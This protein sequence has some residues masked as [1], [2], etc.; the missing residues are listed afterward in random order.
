M[1]LG[2]G[3]KKKTFDQ[4]PSNPSPAVSAVYKLQGLNT[5]TEDWARK[6]EVFYATQEEVNAL[7][8]E[9][10]AE[11][12]SYA[13]RFIEDRAGKLGS[14]PQYGYH[15]QVISG[16]IPRKLPLTDDDLVRLLRWA[17]PY[18]PV[19]YA[20]K[21]VERFAKDHPLS[22]DLQNQLRYHLRPSGRSNQAA[23]RL[24]KRIAELLGEELEE[25]FRIDLDQPWAKRLH[26]D[27][28]QLDDAYRSAMTSFLTHAATAE[29]GKP[30]KAWL[31]EAQARLEPLPEDLVTSALV[32]WGDAF[33]LP[34]SETPDE[35]WPRSEWRV[36]EANADLM[37]G[38]LWIATLVAN[39]DL[40]R[41]VTK[42]GVS[43][44]R[45][46]PEYGPR[47]GKVTNAAVWALG[48]IDRPLA[49][50]QLAILRSKIKNKSVQKQIDKAMHAAADRLG[51]PADE[52]EE[53]AVPEYGLT[54]V[55]VRREAFGDFTTELHVTGTG[56]TELRWIKPDGKP[57]KSVPK[58]VKDDHADD[59]KELKAAAKDIQKI[60]PAQ[61]DR[62]D[63]MHLKQKSW[64]Y[65]VWAEHYLNHPLVGALARRLIWTLTHEG[66]ATTATWLDDGLVDAEGHPVSV[67]RACAVA[68]WHPVGNAE[69]DILA[70]RAFFENRQIKQ[71]F[72]QAH[73]EVYL[74]T[75][76]ERNTNVYSNRFAAHVIKQHQFNALCGVR[77]WK[78][79]LR[80]LVD[81]EYPPATLE[82]PEWD[83]RAEFWV[84]G[85]GDDYGTDTNETGTFLRLA[86][87]QV[88]F[89]PLG[90]AQNYAHAGG[91]GYTWSRYRGEDAP[92]AV[93]L[94]Q[95][96]PLVFSEV[97]R[98]VDLFVG[99]A[100]VGND[101][102][103]EDGGPE[104]RFRDY[105]Q[106]YSFGDLSGTATTRKEILERLV[107]RLK[108][109]DRCSFTA[110]FLVVRGDVRTYKIHLG[111]GNILMEPNDQYL[112]IV[113]GRGDVKGPAGKV[114]LPFEGDRTL[115]IILSKAFL[116]ADDTKITD[117]TILSQIK[118]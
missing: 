75:D 37:K 82:L 98:D 116:L 12:V 85:I 38:L 59:L 87:D 117:R 94:D 15:G 65:D 56:T 114:F 88:R 74:L 108:I 84:E 54:G 61:R 43:G 11:F 78:N 19:G 102:T 67:D 45:K 53:M 16:L 34:A 93:P 113:P 97:M 20:V 23:Q 55:G 50:G 18:G 1:V 80:L 89:Y 95:I 28:Q 42:V 96:P 68:L 83:L 3:K 66:K 92:E 22:I 104:G 107:P 7:P 70:W 90:T 112:C 76:A 14:H 105:W 8:A 110:R 10:Q 64:A 57:Q 44:Q 27:L 32:V 69:A 5:S 35:A 72:K 118:R 29:G 48:Q 81:D 49:V 109:A 99:V 71:P 17:G 79:S 86:T 47:C 58:A 106:S 101:P 41:T 103:W 25:D 13:L 100:S 6:N 39:D 40:I 30:S 2:F 51:V 9:G 111:S 31:K 24:A 52:V 46:I 21:A 36:D 73:R 26:D 4:M 115:S 33:D 77:G 62:L 91:G 60:L 63:L